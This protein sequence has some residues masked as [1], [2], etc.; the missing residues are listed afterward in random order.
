M[1]VFQYLNHSINHLLFLFAVIVHML[2]CTQSKKILFSQ[3][4]FLVDNNESGSNRTPN[5][6]S[7]NSSQ[8]SNRKPDS[9]K[10]IL[11]QRQG[12]SGRKHQKK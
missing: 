2:L 9:R 11:R 5:N 4:T 3:F 12:T 7:S 6:N 8:N 10:S 1:H